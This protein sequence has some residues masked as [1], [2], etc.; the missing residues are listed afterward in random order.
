MEETEDID[1]AMALMTSLPKPKRPVAHA[2]KACDQP[3]GDE[4]ALKGSTSQVHMTEARTK[5]L[6]SGARASLKPSGK[7][8]PRVASRDPMAPRAIRP[9]VSPEESSSQLFPETSRSIA[10]LHEAVHD[11][12]DTVDEKNDS[13][14]LDEAPS[15]LDPLETADA[16]DGAMLA[17][18]VEDETQEEGG[19]VQLAS[20]EEPELPS[21]EEAEICDS[22]EAA[23]ETANEGNGGQATMTSMSPMAAPVPRA[24]GLV[25]DVSP[26]A[27]S[28]AELKAYLT[29]HKYP[30]PRKAGLAPLRAAV[31][32]CRE[33]MARSIGSPL[34]TRAKPTQEKTP[35]RTAI[36]AKDCERLGKSGCD[37]RDAQQPGSSKQEHN[38]RQKK[39]DALNVQK[40]STKRNGK[41]MKRGRKAPENA[42]QE[43]GP[44]GDASI[45]ANQSKKRSRRF[46]GEES[47][48]VNESTLAS[49][50]QP[51]GGQKKL[52]RKGSGA[53]GT[54]DS[55]TTSKT[56]KKI[57][58]SQNSTAPRCGAS[59]DL[60]KSGVEVAQV[61]F[62]LSSDV[63]LWQTCH[64]AAVALGCKRPPCEEELL[65]ANVSHLVT[66]NEPRRTLKILMAMTKGIK[67]V[68]AR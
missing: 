15:T 25:L 51:T 54:L 39:R 30:L 8:A 46:S 48:E 11:H 16:I 19:C 35:K 21:T 59:Q 20:N 60:K 67:I 57:K 7:Q 43:S 40:G 13:S 29:K 38:C 22:E 42:A 2:T 47:S 4:I 44:E 23:A 41:T 66:T 52:Q 10:P 36:V 14:E 24:L 53:K 27:N 56:L 26:N 65:G 31:A 61:A 28:Y 63:T 3:H 62:S 18:Q 64:A 37:E 34:A 58:A 12:P 45:S 17:T 6:S 50:E 1:E 49:V 32:S 68:R 9:L 5:K 55:S 33:L